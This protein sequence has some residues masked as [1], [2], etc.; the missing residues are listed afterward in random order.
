M[1]NCLVTK[2]KSIVDNDNLPY[3]EKG[4]AF[5]DSTLGTAETSTAI[6]NKIAFGP[7]VS[8]IENM[9]S[10]IFELVNYSTAT[11]RV[12]SGATVPVNYTRKM[13]YKLSDVTEIYGPAGSGYNDTI[14]KFQLRIMD[15]AQCVNITRLE[16]NSVSYMDAENPNI[17][18]LATLIKC[19]FFGLQ[20]YN[21]SSWV[22]DLVPFT[23]KLLA[24]GLNVTQIPVIVITNTGYN[25]HLKVNG[26][27]EIGYA[28]NEH[29][30]FTGNGHYSIYRGMT[31]NAP[32]EDYSSYT[33]T[34]TK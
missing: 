6:F 12:K 10:N 21:M 19:S 3:L 34:Y 4:V 7:N 8:N 30:V 9:D 5:Y 16:V 25:C 15:I 31:S 17:E 33:P 24:N 26:V 1:K 22:G 27:E 28:R 23:D 2:L 13:F 14:S 29:I 20:G 32:L 11:L 18:D